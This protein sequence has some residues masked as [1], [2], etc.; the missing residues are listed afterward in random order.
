MTGDLTWG[1]F[2][3]PTCV[4]FEA[5]EWLR[6]ENAAPPAR[7]GVPVPLRRDS[8]AQA[9]VLVLELRHA[10]AGVHEAGAAPGPGG[11]REG[12]DLEV[13]RVPFLAPGG[14]HLDHGAVRHLDV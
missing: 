14:L 11:V 10:A 3:R 1:K 12:V 9:G 13:H 6:T 4:A 5:T 7:R 8:E 2:E